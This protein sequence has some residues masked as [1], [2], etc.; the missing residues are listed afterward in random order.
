MK[1]DCW[2]TRPCAVGDSI[3]V[4]SHRYKKRLH[5]LWNVQQCYM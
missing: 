1:L 4:D 5:K 2:T 3:N